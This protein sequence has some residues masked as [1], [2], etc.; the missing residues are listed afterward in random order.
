MSPRQ[1]GLM[2][3]CTI[4]CKNK[5]TTNMQM[6]TQE[7]AKLKQSSNTLHAD[8]T[9]HNCQAHQQSQPNCSMLPQTRRPKTASKARLE[10]RGSQSSRL[11]PRDHPPGSNSNM[12]RPIM[13]GTPRVRPTTPAPSHLRSTG[14]ASRKPPS[15]K[16]KQLDHTTKPEAARLKTRAAQPTLD[17]TE[18]KLNPAEIQG[19][20]PLG[21][22]DNTKE[23]ML[24]V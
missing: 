16:Q 19:S 15:K 5:Q 14:P 23:R 22:T 10:L 1:I 21:I 24:L 6:Q 3:V 17:A 7:K 20:P 8:P 4:Q 9:D 18:T 12:V 11:N 13:E 2:Q